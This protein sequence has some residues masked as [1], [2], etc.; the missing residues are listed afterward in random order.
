MVEIPRAQPGRLH[1]A[2]KHRRHAKL[3]QLVDM[4]AD[5]A[6]EQVNAGVFCC[7]SPEC[8]EREFAA[9]V[10]GG[11]FVTTRRVGVTVLVGAIGEIANVSQ[12]FH[13]DGRFSAANSP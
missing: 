13:P 2:G 7:G 1:L 3:C 10:A 4:S 8:N 11:Y 6:V 9:T 5:G 12:I